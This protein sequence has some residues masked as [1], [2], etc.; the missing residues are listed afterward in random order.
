MIFAGP[1]PPCQ[2]QGILADIKDRTGRPCPRVE[3]DPENFVPADL[4]KFI[5]DERLASFAEGQF[6]D[7]ASDWTALERIEIRNR[8]AGAIHSPEVQ[9]ILNP[10]KS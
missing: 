6:Q 10:K 4:V 7:Y 3:L 1:E 5:L 8:L 2:N 9:D